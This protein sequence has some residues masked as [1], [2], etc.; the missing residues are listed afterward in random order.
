MTEDKITKDSIVTLK[1]ITEKTLSPILKLEVTKEQL[2]FVAPNA[3]S[4]AQAHFS[5]K[6]WF[7]AIYAGETPVGFAVTSDLPAAE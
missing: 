7:R 3:V 4:I 6:A 5:D 2:Q 1:E